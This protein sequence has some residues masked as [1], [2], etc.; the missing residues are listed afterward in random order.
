MRAGHRGP[1]ALLADLRKC[2]CVAGEEVVCCL[3]VGVCHIAQG[4]DAYFE[5]V[6]TVTR[7]KARLAIEINE[8]AKTLRFAA[9]DGNHERESER[10]GTRERLRRTPYA[11]PDGQGILQ[12]P[13]IDALAGKG[14]AVLSRPVD[15][16]VFANLEKQVELFCEQG[17]VII[18]IEPEERK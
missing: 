11:Q 8:R 13:G 5:L 9:D 4:M 3:R 17:I 15:M 18:E 2:F 14:R 12:R 6:S 10:A 16:G 1:A 7:A